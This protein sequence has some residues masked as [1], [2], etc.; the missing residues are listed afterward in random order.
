M[1]AFAFVTA[2]VSIAVLV[3]MR[4]VYAWDGPTATVGSGGRL[5]G[6]RLDVLGTKVDA[7]LGVRYAEPPVGELRF[8][9][10]KPV[11]ETWESNSVQNATE[12]GNACWQVDIKPPANFSGQAWWGTTD[13]M[14]EDCLFLNIWTPY[15]RPGDVPV[16]V[17]IHGGSFQ[18]GA[19]ST[20][21]YRGEILATVEN[22]VVV[23]M[24]YR[25]GSLGFSAFYTENEPGNLGLIDQ[26][27][28]LR[29]VKRNI[30]HFGGDPR[31]IT[32]IGHSA[33]AASVGF[34]LLSPMIRK[35]KLFHRAVL[36]SGTPNAPWA[37]TYRNESM[38]RVGK[39][40]KELN[41][42]TWFESAAIEY[43][44]IVQQT[45]LCLRH[46]KPQDFFSNLHSIPVLNTVIVDGNFIPM[47]PQRL[48]TLHG[49]AGKKRRIPLLIGTVKDD[50]VMNIYFDEFSMSA[51]I[52]KVRYTYDEQ[53][54][55]LHV[56]LL[57]S[58]PG[59]PVADAAAFQYRDWSDPDNG[60][61]L[62][63]GVIDMWSDFCILCPLKEFASF[64]SRT[65]ND[66]FAY[67]FNHRP[68]NSPYPKWMNILH[69]DDLSFTLGRA[70]DAEDNL[71]DDEKRLS[72]RIMRYLGNFARSGD[73]NEPEEFMIKVQNW[74]KYRDESPTY[75]T[76]DQALV[77]NSALVGQ[78]GRVTQCAFWSQLVP[79]LVNEMD[80][81][82]KSSFRPY[83]TPGY[84][85]MFLGYAYYENESEENVLI[86]TLNATCSKAHQVISTYLGVAAV[87]FATISCSNFS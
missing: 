51:D 37:I 7:F 8:R 84:H 35:Q 24:N 16:F 76:L 54:Y 82:R 72:R 14:S 56:N 6:R 68:S 64:Y 21:V 34:H 20:T 28:A 32:L 33:G 29:W 23:S 66:V 41:C 15:P 55:E 75:L 5:L 83:F 11:N 25:L 45:L 69:G 53:T 27:I 80:R 52:D 85:P 87:L 30:E 26:A 48:L 73:P 50:A 58:Y 9:V 2:T 79:K 77:E 70:L 57:L 1:D 59:Q 18:M 17:F 81:M 36:Q 63:R 31:R 47:D 86:R 61:L 19:T 13:K 10:A 22:C 38:W 3:S 39:I 4:P 78:F 62:H 46:R 40:A 49:L 44:Q 60:A 42:P 67:T 74:P 71:T 12:F 65:G 43:D